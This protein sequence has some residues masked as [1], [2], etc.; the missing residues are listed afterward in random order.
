MPS[1]SKPL[2]LIILRVD[3]DEILP[4]FGDVLFGE[5]R[6][7]WADRRARPAIY[8]RAWVNIELAHVGEVGLVGPRVNA[9]NR[10]DLD[11]VGVLFVY[12]RLTDDKRHSAS[13]T[14]N[15]V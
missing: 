3:L 7:L 14:A 4:L 8:T 6:L 13:F 5:D 10:T 1:C 12:T 2:F 15:S 11:A 9:I